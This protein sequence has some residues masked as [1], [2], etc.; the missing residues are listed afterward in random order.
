MPATML[1]N[2][3]I[4]FC[5]LSLLHFLKLPL[6]FSYFPIVYSPSKTGNVN[7]CNKDSSRTLHLIFPARHYCPPNYDHGTYLERQVVQP[8][9]TFYMEPV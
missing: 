9:I 2:I 4:L 5:L 6:Q 7:K 3:Y 8:Q 1:G